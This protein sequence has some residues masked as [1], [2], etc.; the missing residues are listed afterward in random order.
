MEKQFK[1]VK[2]HGLPRQVIEE[3]RSYQNMQCVIIKKSK[4]F[5]KQEAS[6]LLSKLRTSILLSNAPILRDVLFQEVL[7]T[8]FKIDKMVNKSLLTGDN[9]MPEKHLK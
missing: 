8:A 2:T 3:Q 4:F 6:G 5:R 1:K 7:E 9:L